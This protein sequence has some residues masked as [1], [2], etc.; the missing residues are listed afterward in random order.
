VGATNLSNTAQANLSS[1]ANFGLDLGGEYRFM[2][3]LFAYLSGG[4]RTYSFEQPGSGLFLANSTPTTWG[5][6]GGV[7]HPFSR[8]AAASLGLGYKEWLTLTGVSV[9]ALS[10]DEMRIPELRAGASYVFYRTGALSTGISGSL[11]LLFPG[12]S[13]AEASGWGHSESILFYADKEAKSLIWRAGL[14]AAN[15]S[16]STKSISVGQQGFSL[17]LGVRYYF[18]S[19][20]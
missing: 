12:A 10:M 14:G 16:F 17:Q 15:T 6:E 13:T 9:A 8:D 19:E 4:V 3:G 20:K 11:A 7:S 2:P 18:P 5:V 1:A